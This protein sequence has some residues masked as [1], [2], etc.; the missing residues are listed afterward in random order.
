MLPSGWRN[1][2]CYHWCDR[3]CC[4]GSTFLYITMLKTGSALLSRRRQQRKLNFTLES[5]GG[6]FLTSYFTYITKRMLFW[7]ITLWIPYVL[8]IFPAIPDS[9]KHCRLC[10]LSD[11]GG[12]TGNPYLMDQYKTQKRVLYCFTGP[13]NPRRDVI[14]PAICRCAASL[15]QYAS[16]PSRCGLLSPALPPNICRLFRTLKPHAIGPASVLLMASAPAAA[17]RW[18]P[19][20]R[21]FYRQPAAICRDLWFSD[22]LLSRRRVSYYLRQNKS[23]ARR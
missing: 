6:T 14:S 15:K 19:N 2:F 17:V 20:G 11:C 21:L 18:Q 23:H 4:C 13:T 12:Y 10:P 9:V 7:G 1:V 22:A 8:S 5:L 3:H 16:L